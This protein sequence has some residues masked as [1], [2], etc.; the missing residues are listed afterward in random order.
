MGDVSDNPRGSCPGSRQPAGG[1]R[2]CC[3]VRERTHEPRAIRACSASSA[4]AAEAASDS[5]AA[6]RAA[7]ALACILVYGG[8]WGGHMKKC[9]YPLS[10]SSQRSPSCTCMHH[11][12]SPSAEAVRPLS[13]M[14]A[15]SAAASR[16]M[17]ESTW[18]RRRIEKI[19]E[20]E[21]DQEGPGRAHSPHAPVLRAFSGEPADVPRAPWRSA[22]RPRH[23][24][25][26]PWPPR[27]ASNG[28]EGEGN[29]I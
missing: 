20:M 1:R 10:M 27:A 15:A 11:R 21:E 24:Q 14:A 9:V 7:A 16:A 25:R 29:K 28:S 5:A 19:Y 23:A 26:Q 3:C 8:V 6:A 2:P 4:K 18:V 12:T 17:R 13:T 22:R